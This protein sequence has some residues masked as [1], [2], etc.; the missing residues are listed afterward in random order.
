M[1][2]YR[3]FNKIMATREEVIKIL[4]SRGISDDQITQAQAPAQNQQAI[5]QQPVAQP[6]QQPTQPQDF[7][8]LLNS[9]GA[10]AA[11]PQFTKRQG[12]ANTLQQLGSS[13]ASSLEGRGTTPIKSLEQIHGIKPG[14]GDL[15]EFA[16]KKAIEK[17]FEKPDSISDRIIELNKGIKSAQDVQ[18]FNT[19]D[20]LIAE[21]NSLL[22]ET[23]QPSVQQPQEQPQQQPIGTPGVGPQGNESF[24]FK[25][26]QQP[27][28]QQEAI[29]NES[30]SQTGIQ[31]PQ[32]LNLEPEIPNQ[33]TGIVDP[34]TKFRNE[35]KIKAFEDKQAIIQK[36][37]LA[38]LDSVS[39]EVAGRVSLAKESIKNIRDVKNILFPDGTAKSFRRNIAMRSNLP[40]IS[41]PFIGRITP[42]V[43]P[44]NPISPWDNQKAQAGQTVF[45]KVQSS[46]GG[47]LLIKSGVAVRPEELER[48]I[49]QFAPRLTSNPEASLE[50]LNELQNFYLDFLGTV[51]AKFR[52][53]IVMEDDQGNMAIVNPETGQVIKE[54]L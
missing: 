36:K 7:Q 2:L 19:V 33:R 38:E 44:D 40:G 22:G 25:G 28:D 1:H 6:Q 39:G 17:K 51:D 14:G 12:L 21:R 46:L 8:S 5:A 48:E 9:V 37:A 35:Q 42:R 16:Q 13:F 52:G 23:S 29:E 24:A 49:D 45:R 34:N 47:R 11:N 4:K 31:L 20:R 3:E 50:G 43:S 26:S 53:T 15:L 27:V 54:L 18:D 10:G 41:L 30:I 32:D